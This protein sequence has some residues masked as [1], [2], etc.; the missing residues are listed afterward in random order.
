MGGFYFE[1]IDLCLD[2]KLT[3]VKDHDRKIYTNLDIHQQEETL[4]K[5]LTLQTQ[6]PD[7]RTVLQ[8]TRQPA[9]PININQA[10][11]GKGTDARLKNFRSS[12]TMP[13]MDTC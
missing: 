1:Q 13:S 12:T 8:V 2:V 9:N 5:L 3:T 10:V 7:T 4:L 6:E 11:A